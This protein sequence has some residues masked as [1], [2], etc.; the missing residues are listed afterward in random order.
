MA[1]RL[2]LRVTLE[3]GDY[4]RAWN[5]ISIKND[6]GLVKYFNFFFNFEFELINIKSEKGIYN[7]LNVSTGKANGD[8]FN[9]SSTIYKILS[10]L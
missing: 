10:E 3:R 9:R 1:D 4:N 7:R 8:G 2:N 5:I 6:N